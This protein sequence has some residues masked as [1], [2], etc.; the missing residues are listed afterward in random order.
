MAIIHYTKREKNGICDDKLARPNGQLRDYQE[1]GSG[2]LFLEFGKTSRFP[3]HWET[4]VYYVSLHMHN[5]IYY[6]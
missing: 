5:E 4:I 1:Q 6:S 3:V 2:Y